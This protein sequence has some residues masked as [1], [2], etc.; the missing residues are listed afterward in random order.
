[1]LKIR[2]LGINA[3]PRNGHRMVACNERTEDCG[4]HSGEAPDC[5]GCTAT[6]ED[7][8]CGEYSRRPENPDCNGCTATG[9]PDRYRA[10]FTAD[11]V[12]QLR[13]QL[14]DRMGQPLGY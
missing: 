7:K 13:Q 11:A 10:A 9:R 4:Q 1:M 8:V 5:D 6:F 2:D 14:D 3:L 12:A